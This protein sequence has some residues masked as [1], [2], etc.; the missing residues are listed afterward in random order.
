M[1]DTSKAVSFRVNKQDIKPLLASVISQIIKRNS[2]ELTNEL[3]S[4]SQTLYDEGGEPQ[5]ILT[6]LNKLV[7]TY[8]QIIKELDDSSELVLSMVPPRPNPMEALGVSFESSANTEVL[9]NL[10]DLKKNSLGVDRGSIEPITITP[11]HPKE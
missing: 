9:E 5:D 6:S 1:G 11:N 2:E 10:S 4:L 3:N 7:L 8:Q